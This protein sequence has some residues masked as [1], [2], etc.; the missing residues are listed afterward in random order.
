MTSAERLY[1]D[2]LWRALGVDPRS[3]GAQ[4]IEGRVALAATKDI[5]DGFA[6]LRKQFDQ[7]EAGKR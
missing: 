4:V 1:L 2:R 6:A 5:A 3:E 7:R